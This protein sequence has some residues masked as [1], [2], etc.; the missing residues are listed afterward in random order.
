MSGRHGAED[1]EDVARLDNHKRPVWLIKVPPRV[2]RAWDAA[3]EE[4]LL[5]KLRI[6]MKDGKG[7]CAGEPER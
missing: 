7:E 4:D 2:A 6:H 3:R 5:G 1:E